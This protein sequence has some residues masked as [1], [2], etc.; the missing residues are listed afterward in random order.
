MQ[1]VLTLQSKLFF[2]FA[3]SSVGASVGSRVAE[4]LKGVL[5]TKITIARQG[6]NA[7]LGACLPSMC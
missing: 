5:V 1:I 4:K 2:V 6:E 7:K 3:K